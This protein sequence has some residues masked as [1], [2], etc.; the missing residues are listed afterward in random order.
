MI[1]LVTEQLTA[2]QEFA[3]AVGSQLSGVAAFVLTG[4]AMVIGSLLKPLFVCTTDAER[5]L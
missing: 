1:Y 4:V 2:T 3:K 5:T